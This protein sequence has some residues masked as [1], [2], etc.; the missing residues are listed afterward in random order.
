M[1]SV[2]EW[3]PSLVY[4]ALASG[5]AFAQVTLDGTAN[6]DFAGPLAGPDYQIR[7]EFGRRAGRNLFHSFD[8]F[9]LRTLDD[10][11]I[12]S[13]TFSGPPEIDHVIS[14]VTGGERS[15]ID[16]KISSTIAGADFYFINPAGIV[17]GPNAELD[18]QGSFHVS[19]AD[20]LRFADGERFSARLGGA[21]SF[22]MAPPEAF[23]FLGADPAPITVDT[24]FLEVVP[25][26]ALSIVGGDIDVS[27]ALLLAPAGEIS[28]LALGEPGAA[29]LSDGVVT[30]G[31][32]ADI[33]LRDG[34]E[35]ET[36]DNG[37]GTIR[38]R[39]GAIVVEDGT[40]VNADNFGARDSEGGIAVDGDRFAMRGGAR[41]TADVRAQG[42]AGA[43]TVTAR[44]LEISGGALIRSSS[45]A[46]GKAGTVTVQAGQLRIFRDGSAAV[47]GIV[48]DA[49]SSSTETGDAGTVRVTAR[50]IDLRDGG[51]IRS[52]T[53]GAGDAGAVEIDAT[54]L[55]VAASGLTPLT[56]ISS[57]VEPAATGSGGTVSVSAGD[58]E[59]R[60]D[61]K[62]RSVT[63]GRENAGKVTVTADRVTLR[64]GGQ[65]SSSTFAAGGGD[66]GDVV[67]TV[68]E[69]LSVS[70]QSRFQTNSGVFPPSGVFA[71]TNS[72]S[73]DAGAAGRVTVT[74]PVIRL[75]DRGEIASESFGGG[76]GG[77]VRVTAESLEIDDAEITT[78]VRGAG[79]GGRIRVMA[80]ALELRNHGLISAQSTGAGAA[81]TVSIE[82]AD[83]LLLLERSEISTD[84]AEAGGGRIR[85]RV[86]DAIV[87]RD[88]FVTTS[89]QGGTD[90]TAGNIT[91]DP[92]VLV[93]D[94]GKIQATATGAP[95]G[96]GGK[97][98]IVADNILVPGG[99]F[100]KLLARRDISA[101]G[102]TPERA[103]TVTVNS[104][105]VD[106]SGGLVVLEGALLDAA[107]QLRERC[108]ARR[109]IGAS[110]FTGVGRGG[111][112]PTPDGPLAGAYV[113]DG[114]V[115]G[116]A[117]KLGSGLSARTAAAEYV[118][119]AGFSAPCAPLD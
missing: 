50:D 62:I 46:A 8:R 70:G 40:M 43:V 17:L 111:L 82:V 69:V 93:I 106:L 63:F 92:K 109:D 7:A 58:L 23:G 98:T 119:L 117:R 55:R 99:D 28:L 18:V 108:G 72:D 12:E 32:R 113:G 14:R 97:I 33:T 87:L 64:G 29:R 42:D 59:L 13:A 6:P 26:E 31:G 73:P 3:L 91:I 60:A 78:K 19:T 25:G 66:S 88:S 81:G 94:G 51:E 54:R 15:D 103:G 100:E 107:A 37:G 83:R 74:A 61:G 48:S 57:Q 36:T 65:I 11:T 110:S 89:V 39:G 95:M 4:L 22:S 102:G 10:D 118:R 90:P 45:F 34:S 49:A 68:R 77:N 52:S 35:L 114:T 56:G 85:L 20:E 84:S 53:F 16:G 24:S 27:G 76:A 30:A 67:L 75:A 38:I 79:D 44:E 2:R 9:D 116:E 96:Q 105:D 86:G 21:S 5:P 71:S 41:L 1:S 104:P 101:S 112:P 47:T 80:G 115:V